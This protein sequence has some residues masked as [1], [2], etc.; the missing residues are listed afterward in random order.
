[1]F[2]VWN[3]SM[4]WCVPIHRNVQD[5]RIQCHADELMC[6]KWCTMSHT[7][8]HSGYPQVN[9]CMHHFLHEIYRQHPWNIQ[10]KTTC[11]MSCVWDHAHDVMRREPGQCFTVDILLH[12]PFWLQTMGSDRSAS[13][14]MYEIM[15]INECV[16]ERRTVQRV[17]KLFYVSFILFVLLYCA[18]FAL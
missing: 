1:M 12:D 3:L 8:E 7:F 10:S 15:R 11:I 5:L 9:R 18:F 13:C 4:M 16:V 2:C 6:M 14:R 17:N